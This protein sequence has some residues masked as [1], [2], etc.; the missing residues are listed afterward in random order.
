M[1]KRRHGPAAAPGPAAQVRRVHVV[2]AV[3]VCAAL[4]LP[5][6]GYDF[7]WDDRQLV[8]ANPRLETANPL[9]FFSQSFI[10][11]L[12]GSEERNVRY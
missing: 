3:L 5:T 9:S 10:P 1:S 11:G 2:L 6:L 12:H 4:Y 8:S 7:V